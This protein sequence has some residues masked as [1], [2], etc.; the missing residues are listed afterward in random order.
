[1]KGAP[2]GSVALIEVAFIKALTTY[3]EPDLRHL[4]SGSLTSVA[5]LGVLI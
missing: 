5:P 1:M 4:C 2:A 3:Q